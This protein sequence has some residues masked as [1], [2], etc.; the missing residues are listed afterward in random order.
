MNVGTAPTVSLRNRI[1]DEGAFKERLRRERRRTERSG[2][3]FL[4][5][6]FEWPSLVADGP[7]DRTL[8]HVLS[9]LSQITRH[10]DTIGWYKDASVLGVIFTDLGYEDTASLLD[11]IF[12]G[13]TTAL[14][15][16]P[17][18]DTITHVRLAFQIFPEE[19]A[20][21][22][23]RGNGDLLVHAEHLSET[24]PRRVSRVT[25]NVIDVAG[26]CLG[27]ILTFPLLCAIALAVK[28]T[29]PGPV[30]FRQQRIG[31]N[32]KRFTFLKFRSMYTASDETIHKRYVEYFMSGA[33]GPPGTTGQQMIFKLKNDPRVT[34]LGRFL[35]STSLDELPQLFNVLRGEMSLVGPRPP[36]PYEFERYELW[37]RRRLLN[38]KP[39]VT[40]LW[41]VGGRSRVTFDEMVRLDLEYVDTWSLWLD[42]KILLRTPAAVLSGEGAY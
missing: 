17:G 18:L 13:V 29:S 33:P 27:L 25:K 5:V 39:G 31:Q 3:R 12:K 11:H 40:G 1:C 19:N 37:H 35:R 38:V 20:I 6:L 15:R 28:L 14:S 34:R 36:V 24:D 42:F 32:G 21:C 16:T 41:Q 22:G 30:L 2:T 7:H 9:S 8:D 10:P 26:S 23:Q 4:M